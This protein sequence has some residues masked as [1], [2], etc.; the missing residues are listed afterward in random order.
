MNENLLPIHPE[1]PHTKNVFAN[2]HLTISTPEVSF[3]LKDLK[4]KLSHELEKEIISLNKAQLEVN[5]VEC[6]VYTNV[7]AIKISP[8]TI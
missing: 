3:K 2:L 5:K 6:T 8:I 1:I 7:H 4:I